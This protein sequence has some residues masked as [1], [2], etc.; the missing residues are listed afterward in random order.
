MTDSAPKAQDPKSDRAIIEGIKRGI[1]D[2]ET[3][4]TVCHNAAM[5]TLQKTIDAES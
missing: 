5:E 2:I 3:G 4:R 1:A